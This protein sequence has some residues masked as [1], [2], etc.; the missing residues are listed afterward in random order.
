MSRGRTAGV[1]YLLIF[2]LAP[3]VFAG[4]KA[5]ALVPGDPV[6]T[7]ANVEGLVGH[8]RVGLV[9]ESLIIFIEIALAAL[10]YVLFRRVGPT[11][12][13]AAAFARV[14][15]AFV[16]GVN[17]LP[18][19][20]ALLLLGHAGR[21]PVLDEGTAQSTAYLMLEANEFLILVWGLFFGLHLAFLGVL[22]YRSGTVPRLIG[23]LLVVAASGYLLEGFGTIL[24]PGAAAWLGNAV[25]ILA[26]P[27]ELAFA[28][29]LL[30]R[31]NRLDA[32]L[33]GRG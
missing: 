31:G 2:L 9:I 4:G 8:F 13:M 21:G 23:G 17:L 22:A 7:A 15:E 32:A 16:Q 14:G 11:L 18:A 24:Q 10:L 5:T 29:W 1:L 28:V 30:A 20:L 27:G 19:F 3:F 33:E 26:V 12:S 6:A 25:V